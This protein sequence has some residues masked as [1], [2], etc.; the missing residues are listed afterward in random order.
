MDIDECV[1][2]TEVPMEFEQAGTHPFSISW[3]ITGNA[4][5]AAKRDLE[6]SLFLTSSFLLATC[7]EHNLRQLFLCPRTQD[8]RHAHSHQRAQDVVLPA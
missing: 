8:Q 2:N 5:W 3:T 7:V 6:L 4:S 1:E